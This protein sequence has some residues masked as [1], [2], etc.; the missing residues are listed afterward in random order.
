MGEANRR[1]AILGD[2][3]GQPQEPK[4]K[5]ES[6]PE[7][8]PEP[9]KDEAKKQYDTYSLE[10]GGCVNS[11]QN[12]GIARVAAQAKRMG[13]IDGGVALPFVVTINTGGMIMGLAFPSVGSKDSETEI[14]VG[15]VVTNIFEISE[16]KGTRFY[17]D[18]EGDLR[19]KIALAYREWV[20]RQGYLS[21][22]IGE[23]GVLANDQLK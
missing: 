19:L 2:L 8:R 9:Q 22:V 6:K 7:P 23:A 17:R 20:H 18:I 12:Q 21:M 3:F 11:W 13:V 1:K 15:M 16:E 4:I 5:L 10:L 14:V